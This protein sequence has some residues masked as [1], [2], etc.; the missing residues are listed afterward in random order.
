MI[1]FPLNRLPTVDNSASYPFNFYQHLIFSQ[2]Y[3][4]INF[5]KKI[6]DGIL[7]SDSSLDL[8][9]S[10]LKFGDYTRRYKVEIPKQ[11]LKE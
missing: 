2:I 7:R 1:Y 6:I 3:Y 9:F 5:L 11:R 4:L 8:R 10:P